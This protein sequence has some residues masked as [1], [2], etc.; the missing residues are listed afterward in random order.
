MGNKLSSTKE[1]NNSLPTSHRD[2]KA[3]DTLADGSYIIMLE[4][5]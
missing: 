2:N 4:D 5:A 1:Y 3:K